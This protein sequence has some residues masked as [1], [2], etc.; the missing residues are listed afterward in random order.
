MNDNIPRTSCSVAALIAITGR[1]AFDE[2]FMSC[3]KSL[4]K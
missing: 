4:T 3:T 1:A 2:I